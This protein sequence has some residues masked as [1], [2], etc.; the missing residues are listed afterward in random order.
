M[1]WFDASIHAASPVSMD[2]ISHVMLGAI[3]RERAARFHIAAHVRYPD[4]NKLQ[5]YA[6]PIRTDA[7]F[8]AWAYS[9]I[10]PFSGS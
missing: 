1:V 6:T 7:G 2:V 4:G 10:G 3:D 9:S 8:G 5:A